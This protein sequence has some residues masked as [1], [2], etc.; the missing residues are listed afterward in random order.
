M[1]SDLFSKPYIFDIMNKTEL[2]AAMAAKSGL[3]KVDCKKALDG[4]MAAVTDALKSGENV[5]LTGFGA[6]S[7][8]ERSARK[9]V[10]PQTKEPIEIAA[11]K[12]VKF[13]AGA[14][15]ADAIA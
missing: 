8:T 12:S 11:K 7:V 1:L 5:A 4:M 9:G 15:L 3:S 10:N 14:D 13:K 2:V 6:F